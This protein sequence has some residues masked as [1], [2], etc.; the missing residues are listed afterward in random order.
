ME[1]AGG[2]C[3]CSCGGD[4]AQPCASGGGQRADLYVDIAK[5]SRQ[6]PRGPILGDDSPVVSLVSKASADSRRSAA[7]GPRKWLRP[8]ATATR[9]DRRIHYSGDNG[10]GSVGNDSPGGG[11]AFMEDHIIV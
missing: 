10:S 11:H 6:G 5:T 4:V 2:G 9:T 8:E 7:L 3:D 1:A